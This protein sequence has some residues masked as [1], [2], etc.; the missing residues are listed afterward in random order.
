MLDMLGE[1]GHNSGRSRS[2]EQQERK[3]QA[4]HASHAAKKSRA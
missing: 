3:G 2:G 4:V 1:I